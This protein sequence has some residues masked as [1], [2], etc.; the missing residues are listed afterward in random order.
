MNEFR[1][2][3]E[4]SPNPRTRELL[5]TGLSDRPDPGSLGR[6][7]AAL[8]ALGTASVAAPGISAAS[9]AGSIGQATTV[10]VA[11]W[12]GVG[13]VTGGLLGTGAATVT[14]RHVAP[15]LR[16]H[17]AGVTSAARVQD[18]RRRPPGAVADEG[19]RAEPT[20]DDR[21]AAAVPISPSPR[22][23]ATRSPSQPDESARVAPAGDRA[24]HPSSGEVAEAPSAATAQ[25]D[26]P[27][28]LAAEVA[29]IDRAKQMLG[30]GDAA[31]A[32]REL[33]VYRR[34]RNTGALEREALVLRIESLARIGAT[35]EARRLAQ[36]YL[37]TFPNDAH[38]GRLRDLLARLSQAHRDPR[39][40][41]E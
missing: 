29:L 5:E 38:G 35:S 19:S 9:A 17:A 39:G 18:S 1:R 24:G 8:G 20:S 6:T 37:E 26:D 27:G 15:E 14:A 31:G 32:L 12:I 13:L 36:S 34:S 4:S 41:G 33:D 3:L 21:E 11:K 23:A 22:A 25:V 10:L 2:L 28:R 40:I 16:P 7:A 30:R